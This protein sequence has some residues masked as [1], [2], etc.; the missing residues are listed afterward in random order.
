M[1]RKDP[2]TGKLNWLGCQESEYTEIMDSAE[3]WENPEH[4]IEFDTLIRDS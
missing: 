4:W 2:K 3:D 1:R